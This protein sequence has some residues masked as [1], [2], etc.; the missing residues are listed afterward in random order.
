[1]GTHTMIPS[2]D[3]VHGRR[4]GWLCQMLLSDNQNSILSINH[5]VQIKGFALISLKY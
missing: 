2:E 3:D 1:M 5:V 4:R